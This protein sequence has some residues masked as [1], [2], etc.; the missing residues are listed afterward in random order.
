[1]ELNPA[2][3]WS[4]VG[5]PMT[6]YW[7]QSC[8]KTFLMI[9]MM[10]LCTCPVTDNTNLWGWGCCSAREWES[11][12]RLWAG[13]ISGLRP[14][15]WNSI[16]LSPA[17]GPMQCYWQ[18]EEWLE[19]CPLEKEMLARGVGQHEAEHEPPVPRWP[20]RPMVS[21]PLLSILWS[22]GPG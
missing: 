16:R 1:M 4:W 12:K 19:S 10:G 21:W 5:F 20:K 17:L 13:W 6:L 18:G 11:Y 22:T 14:V 15:G 7:G 8:L 9:W 3:G 2:G